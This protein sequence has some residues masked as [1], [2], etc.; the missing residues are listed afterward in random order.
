[1]VD[2]M[3]SG[4]VKSFDAEKGYGFIARDGGDDVFVPPRPDRGEDSGRCR[5]SGSRSGPRRTGDEARS[6]RVR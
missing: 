2:R 5:A 3:V 4:T 1:V 6:V